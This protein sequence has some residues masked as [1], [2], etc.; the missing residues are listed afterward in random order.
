MTPAVK[1]ILF[2]NVAVFLIHF[3]LQAFAQSPIVAT[4]FGLKPSDLFERGFVWQLVTYLFVH[5]AG[6]FTR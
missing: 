3:V 5:D 4:V 1:A 2:A 6:G